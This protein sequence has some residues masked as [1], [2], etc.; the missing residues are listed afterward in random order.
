[1]STKID[2]YLKEYLETLKKSFNIKAYSEMIYLTLIQ[3][4]VMLI[5]MGVSFIVI[6]ALGLLFFGKYFLNSTNLDFFDWNTFFYSN[7]I[8]FEV[9][10]FVIFIFATIMTIIQIYLFLAQLRVGEGVL[11]KK[12]VTYKSALKL[13]KIGFFRVFRTIIIL[14]IIEFLLLVI[15]SAPLIFVLIQLLPGLFT[16]PPEIFSIIGFL[17]IIFGGIIL[18]FLL[19]FLIAPIT[20]NLVPISHF[21]NKGAIYSLK[22][23]FVRA[24]KDYFMKLLFIF[25]IGLV[26]GII[27]TIKA[28]FDQAYEMVNKVGISIDPT[29]IGFNEV[30]VVVWVL[31][32]SFLLISNFV[33]STLFIALVNLFISPLIVKFYQL[34]KN[35]KK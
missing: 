19:F 35:T 6:G 14:S 22:Q 5:L 20:M 24:K 26:S 31:F 34:S 8:N 9:I 10:V 16:T 18:I 7:L 1:M 30:G 33:I 25:G 2:Y 29:T 4:L 32:I 27:L 15:I 3:E 11:L 28:I 17:G 23:G 12:V 21:E 13:A